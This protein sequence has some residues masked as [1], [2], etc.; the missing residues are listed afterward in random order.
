MREGRGGVEGGETGEGAGLVRVEEGTGPG[1]EGKARGGDAF[2]DLGEGL[3]EDNNPEGGGG[4]IGGL[5][6][7]VQDDAVGF[8]EG[9]GVVPVLKYRADQTREEG[10]TRLV[11]SFPD[12]VGY[13]VRARGGQTGRFGEGSGDLLPTDREVIRVG[14]EIDVSR[15]RGWGRGE[16]VV[17]EGRV[18]AFWSVF[19]REGGEAR[20]LTPGGNLLRFPHR[21]RCEGGEVTSPVRELGL[22]YGTEVGPASRPHGRVVVGVP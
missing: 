11:D 15:D 19:V 2:H 4:V 12:I 13:G 6:W 10:G 17:E 8:L 5:A 1:N 22:L 9:R 7:L 20:L 18:D 16:E 14:G 3:K 21:G